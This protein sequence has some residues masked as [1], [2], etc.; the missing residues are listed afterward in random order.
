MLE[1]G[2]WGYFSPFRIWNFTALKE[3]AVA[4]SGRWRLVFRR[5]SF[6]AMRG[7]CDLCQ[8]F[9]E[10]ASGGILSVDLVRCHGA[11]LTRCDA[12]ARW[13]WLRDSTMRR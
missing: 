4:G 13:A 7:R 9:Q 11:T 8:D 1:D 6:G 2:R 12:A 3:S 5:C 10:A